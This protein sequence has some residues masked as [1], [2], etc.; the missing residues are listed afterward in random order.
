ML[1]RSKGGPR[2]GMFLEITVEDGDEPIPGESHGFAVLRDAQAAGDYDVL[3]AHG[4]RVA[5]VHL[6]GDVDAGLAALADAFEAAAT[7]RT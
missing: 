5:R 7:V 1:F 6:S 3:A 2:T 4:L